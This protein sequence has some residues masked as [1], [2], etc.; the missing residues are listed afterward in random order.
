[1]SDSLKYPVGRFALERNSNSAMR[2]NWINQLARAPSRLRE[3]V[4][5]SSEAQLGRTYR[6]GGWTVR[7]IVHHLA[8]SHLNGA[9]RIRLALTEDTPV[10]KT[11]EQDSW[12]QL[13]DASRAPIEPSLQII[14]GVH[15]RLVS[16]LKSLDEEGFAAKIQ[17]PEWGEFSV[18]ANLQ[19]YAWH[20]LHHLAH[21]EN[22]LEGKDEG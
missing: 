2:A 9:V 11:Y 21:I 17:H 19:L 15:A 18:D 22:A 6:P 1:M 13:H 20:S 12:A 8:D 4:A 10:I 16:L 14:D 7:Q 3:L 5:D